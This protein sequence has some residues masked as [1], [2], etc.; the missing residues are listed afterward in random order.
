LQ[1]ESRWSGFTTHIRATNQGKRLFVVPRRRT[2]V[3]W[4]A[5]TIAFVWAIGL[6]AAFIYAVGWL[7]WMLIRAATLFLA[8]S[9]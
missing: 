8:V 1:E 7:L 4:V 2:W 5:V 9:G 6:V 3:W